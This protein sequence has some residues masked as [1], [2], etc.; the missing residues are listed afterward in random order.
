MVVVRS[1]AATVLVIHS[2]ESNIC[3]D[4]F[5]ELSDHALSTQIGDDEKHPYIHH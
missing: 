2:N 1:I 3:S 5:S 4:V